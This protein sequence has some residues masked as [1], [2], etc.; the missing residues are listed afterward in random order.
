MSLDQNVIFNIN[1]NHLTWKRK[2]SSTAVPSAVASLGLGKSGLFA[3]AHLFRGSRWG[4]LKLDV[5]DLPG[6]KLYLPRRRWMEKSCANFCLSTFS[7]ICTPSLRSWRWGRQ[8]RWASFRLSLSLIYFPPLRQW[9]QNRSS[10]EPAWRGSR[11]NMRRGGRREP[12]TEACV[13]F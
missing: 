2:I 12:A 9:G 7:K 4:P 6:K 5:T 3:C 1:F 13:D 11:G 8:W 10:A